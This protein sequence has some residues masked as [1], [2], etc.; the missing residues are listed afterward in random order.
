MLNTARGR[1]LRPFVIITTN[2]GHQRSIRQHTTCVLFEQYLL[3]LTLRVNPA[4]NNHETLYHKRTD[5]IG[6]GYKVE[7]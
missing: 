1:K 2:A 5:K 3:Q 6:N 4:T 7:N